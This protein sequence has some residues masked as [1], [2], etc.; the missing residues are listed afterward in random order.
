MV[1]TELNN[2]DKKAFWHNNIAQNN[3][4]IF[5]ITETQKAVTTWSTGRSSHIKTASIVN[6]LMN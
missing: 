1:A 4:N 5:N 6:P 2:F 3:I